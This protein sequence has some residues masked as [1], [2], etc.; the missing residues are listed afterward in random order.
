MLRRTLS[1]HRKLEVTHGISPTAGIG[2][3]FL[4]H[5]EKIELASHG[6]IREDSPVPIMTGA[7]PL[8]AG[9]SARGA[10]QLRR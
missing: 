8:H 9:I 3:E 2:T 1:S 5:R 10:N 6:S 7:S 4:A